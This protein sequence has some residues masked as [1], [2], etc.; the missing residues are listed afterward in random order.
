[1]SRFISRVP[2]VLLGLLALGVGRL[3]SPALGLPVN[4]ALTQTVELC[5]LLG[6]ALWQLCKKSGIAV[7]Q[8]PVILSFCWLL[9]ATGAIASGLRWASHIAFVALLL[10]LIL[11]LWG[12]RHGI[13]QAISDS[14]PVRPTNLGFWL[15]LILYLAVAPW[16]TSQRPPDGD[17]PYYLLVAHSLAWDLDAD[18]SN[19]YKSQ[20]SLIFMDRAL[21]P[22]PGD[23]VGRE[24]QLY[25]RHNALLAVLLAIPYRLAGKAGAI[26][27]MALA[28]ATLAWWGLRLMRRVYPEPKHVRAITNVWTL[29]AL[30]PPLLLYSSQI[31]TEVPAALLVVIAFD[32]I[33]FPVENS[34]QSWVRLAIVVL[35]LP[36]LKFRFALIAGTLVLL[37]IQRKTSPRR[38]VVLV[39][40]LGLV[41]TLIA[42]VN[43]V[44]FGSVLKHYS[45]TELRLDQRPLIA[46]VRGSLGLFFDGA[47]G[48]FAAAPLWALL[49]PAACLP[50][51]WKN[52][53]LQKSLWLLAPY[54][55]LVVSRQEWFGGWSPPFRY[56]IVAL[57]FLA[58]ALVPLFSETP[59]GAGAKLLVSSL[60]A[61]TLCLTITWLVVPGWT[62]NLA[63][64]GTHLTDHLAHRTGN[65]I[66]RLFPTYV[67]TSLAGWIW[68][69]V[70]SL[71]IIPLWRLK[72]TR[73]ALAPATGP[74]W[75][76]LIA[77]LLLWAENRVPTFRIEFED[78][79]ITATP[80]SLYPERWTVDRQSF[81]GGRLL[82]EGGSLTVPVTT[83]SE[84]VTLEFDIRYVQNQEFLRR[85]VVSNGDYDIVR[86]LPGQPDEWQSIQVGPFPWNPQAPLDIRWEE[87]T[88]TQT[89]NAVILD[90]VEFQ[91]Q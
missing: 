16:T 59:R 80:G 77:T 63:D 81:R 5:P 42:T 56:A 58:L 28:T 65:D 14:E 43:L 60:G 68:P 71:L 33:L 52:R 17:E 29:F 91:W 21:E 25:S 82:I 15:P 50:T 64:G 20:D 1:M 8:G 83:A 23:P 49:L 3:L 70:M 31:W 51:V 46:Y 35:T 2:T 37:A 26:L 55:V 24:G 75:I 27:A 76:L 47:F 62:Y 39:L 69:A 89:P 53:T 18:L 10:L 45:L 61:L 38:L 9:A 67:R 84:S 6:F 32:A 13:R 22:Q 40:G 12:L 44:F 90:R 4:E 57:P 7:T 30:A 54:F 34:S 36:F 66:R 19:N 88:P 78:P 48:L 79:Q 86:W 41:V 87:A 72:R 74:L 85:L 73:L 11:A